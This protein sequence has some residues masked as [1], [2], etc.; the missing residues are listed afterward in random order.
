[1]QPTQEES[2]DRLFK[3]ITPNEEG[4]IW[5]EDK[6]DEYNRCADKFKKARSNFRDAEIE[7]RRNLPE[8]L[9][10]T[11]QNAEVRTRTLEAK[12]LMEVAEIEFRQ[13]AHNYSKFIEGINTEKINIRTKSAHI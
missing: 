7:A 3:I 11:A 6:N 12:K 10:V 13:A 8:G 9:S 5:Y 1:M 2:E 4:I